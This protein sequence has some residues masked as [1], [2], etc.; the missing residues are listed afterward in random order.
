MDSIETIR[1]QRLAA[2]LKS[3]AIARNVSPEVVWETYGHNENAVLATWARVRR[4]NSKRATHR[5]RST[6]CEKAKTP[7][8][9]WETHPPTAQEQK[10]MQN[11]EYWSMIE[12]VVEPEFEPLQTER[13]GHRF[14]PR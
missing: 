7:R 11:R 1:S 3:I 4:E 9:N 13:E 8:R 12:A 10:W 14:D 6:L 5:P 2:A